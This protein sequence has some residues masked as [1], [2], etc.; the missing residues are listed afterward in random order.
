[1]GIV[2]IKTMLWTA[3][4]CV[5]AAVS[6][7]DLRRR[8]IPNEAVAFIAA[9]G[10]ALSLFSRPG[11]TWIGLV[12]STGL[13]LVLAVLSHLA[14]LGAGDAKLIAAVSLLVPPQSVAPLLLGIAVAGGLLS[15]VYLVM[16]RWLPAHA[17]PGGRPARL[18]RRGAFMHFLRRERA[19]I[20]A[21][22]SVPY[23]LAIF[24][25]VLAYVLSELPQ[26]SSE[27]HCLL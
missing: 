9:S 13:L 20:F 23:A 4:L 22:R 12:I 10:L 1:M 18:Q 11:E 25:G 21:S 8:V 3:A 7:V 2:T 19:R 6:V 15:V 27:T 16:R 17:R 5:L 24:A 14:L 26:C